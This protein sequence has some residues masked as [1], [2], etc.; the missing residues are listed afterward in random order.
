M[1]PSHHPDGTHP[2]EPDMSRRLASPGLILAG[3]VT[4]GA[5]GA[6][7]LGAAEQAPAGRASF[8]DDLAFLGASHVQLVT[9]GSSDGAAQVAVCPAWQGRVVTSTATGPGGP[10]LGWINR[11]LIASGKVQPQINAYGGEDRFWIGPEGG[12]FG[13]FFAKGASFDFA[14]W[15]TPAVL[16]TE[17]W[18]VAAQARDRVSFHQAFRLA[19]RAGTVFDLVVDREVRLLEG[20]A[21]WK[22]LGMSA[23][24][25]VSVVA[26][27]SDNRLANAG[28]AAWRKDT[29]LLSIWILGMYPPSPEATVVVPIRTGSEA[30]LGPAVNDAYFG[31]IP[32]DRLA[33]K[34]G[35]A[36][37][38]ADGASRGK[39]GVSPRRCKPVLGSYDA[40]SRLL[41]IVQFTIDPARTDYV[42]SQW[43]IQDHP[44]AGDVAN[45]Y[46][47]GPPAPGAKQLGPFYELESSSA[48]A[49]LAPGQALVHVHRTVHCTGDEA[50]LD[51]IAR[52]VL[53]VS[54]AEIAAGLP[55]R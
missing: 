34:D 6:A 35:V 31:R 16:D 27:E 32:P 14:H 33:V 38:K 3:L 11:E 25:G 46:N 55:R 54:L 44:F 52:T 47:D 48:T 22:K 40:R 5:L 30:E 41:T 26:Y 24:G 23:P 12:Q 9:L 49:E 53:D 36:Y 18:T 37:L 8:A 13:L 15:A 7:E 29:G 1:I 39:I 4:V 2:Q 42:D 45:S 19:N 43:A 50:G 17:P 20:E 21:C 28:T 51:A 10:S